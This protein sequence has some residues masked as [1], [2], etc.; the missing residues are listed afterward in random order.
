VCVC[1]CVKDRQSSPGTACTA[2]LFVGYEE[3]SQVC[4]RHALLSFTTPTL[5][6]A[7]YVKTTYSQREVAHPRPQLFLLGS[8]GLQ[9]DASDEITGE[10]S[11]QEPPGKKNHT[12]RVSLPWGFRMDEGPAYDSSRETTLTRPKVA[13]FYFTETCGTSRDGRKLLARPYL[14]SGA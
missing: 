7:G 1:V 4:M 3:F 6:L 8:R 5:S 10:P 2:Y 14:Q 12:R 11:T 9:T 13:S